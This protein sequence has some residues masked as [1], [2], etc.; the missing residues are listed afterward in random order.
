MAMAINITCLEL[1]GLVGASPSRGSFDAVVC[2]ISSLEDLAESKPAPCGN[3]LAAQR[4][5]V[6]NPCPQ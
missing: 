4:A 1:A 3:T 6:P 2:T 5:S